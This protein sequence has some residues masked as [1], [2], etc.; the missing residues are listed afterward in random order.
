MRKRNCTKHSGE[1]VNRQA[2]LEYGRRV[3]VDNQM[4]NVVGAKLCQQG[5]ELGEKVCLCIP[6]GASVER[7]DEVEA[8]RLKCGVR[9]KVQHL[10]LN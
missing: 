3:D 10:D 4:C 8:K 1:A 9:G 5:G 6:F 7:Q 2:S